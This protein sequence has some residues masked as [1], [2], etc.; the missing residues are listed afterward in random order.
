MLW[1]GGNLEDAKRHFA[2]A[3]KSGRERPYVRHLELAAL[4]NMRDAGDLEMLRVAN[5]MRKGDEPMDPDGPARIW[6]A[7]YSRI[8]SSP[9]EDSIDQLFAAVPPV[10]HIATYRWVFENTGYVESKGVLYEYVLAR[11][12][13]AAGQREP[14]LATYRSVRLKLPAGRIRG[15]VESAIVRLTKH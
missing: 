8:V 1:N 13:E 5:E 14:A 10:E 11:L 4:A 9:A 3:L 7:Y 2:S 12:Q 15:R 6:D